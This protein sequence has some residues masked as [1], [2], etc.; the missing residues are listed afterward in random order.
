M[1]RVHSQGLMPE[2]EDR[3]DCGRGCDTTRE[4]L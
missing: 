1:K 2:E 4:A 3:V